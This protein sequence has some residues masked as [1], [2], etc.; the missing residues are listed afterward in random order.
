MVSI[1]LEKHRYGLQETVSKHLKVARLDF[2]WLI[3]PKFE[4]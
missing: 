4:H 3:P 1:N 2:L